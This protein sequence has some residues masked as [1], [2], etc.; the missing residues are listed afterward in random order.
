MCQNRLADRRFLY[1]RLLAF[2]LVLP[3]AASCASQDRLMAAENEVLELKEERT[4]IKQQNRDLRGQL[5]G[6][7]TALYD[8]DAE[9]GRLEAAYEAEAAEREEA[10]PE[11]LAEGLSVGS[12]GGNLV[13]GVPAEVT[14]SSGKAELTA[15]GRKALSVVAST[16]VAD[17]AAGQ[18]WVEGHTDNEPIRRSGFESNRMLSIAR[19]MAVLTYLV[20]D[21]GIPDGSCVIAGHGEYSPVVENSSVD[22]RALNRRVEIVV[23]M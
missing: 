14:F 2:G 6:Y 12:R 7:E 18:Y 16:L 3:L 13:I 20:E 19:A 15:Q 9:L 22:G 10:H 17:Y 5:Q 1:G 11:L 23:H 8:A 4:Q 21:A